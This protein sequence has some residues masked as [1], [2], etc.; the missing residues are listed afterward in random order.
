MIAGI[1]QSVELAI[2][3]KDK[4]AE[5]QDLFDRLL[6]VTADELYHQTVR[7]V[8][9]GVEETLVVATGGE[10]PVQWRIKLNRNPNLKKEKEDQQ[11]M[12]AGQ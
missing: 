5:R 6:A 8:F 10:A 12:N 9:E 1:N 2:P 4:V 11:K 7:E 3:D